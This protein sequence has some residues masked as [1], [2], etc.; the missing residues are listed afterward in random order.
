[1]QSTPLSGGRLLIVE[2]NPMN[3]IVALRAVSSLGYAGEVASGGEQALE[4]LRRDRFDAVLLDC[5]I[6]GM[7]GYRC[8]ERIRSQETQS[9]AAIRTPIIALTSGGAEGDF[10]RCLSAGIDDYLTKPIRTAALSAALERW[11]GVSATVMAP[12]ANPA[13]ASTRRSDPANG[14]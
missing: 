1:L 6:T 3:Q 10:E 9:G 11:T 2:D 14:H 13:S 7:D 5:H 4:A 12:G 8:A